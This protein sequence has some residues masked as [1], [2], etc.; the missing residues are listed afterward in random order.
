MKY[1]ENYMSDMNTET[2][3]L[4]DLDYWLAEWL[5]PTGKRRSAH[6]ATAY[7]ADVNQ[8]L[9]RA[10]KPFDQI[11]VIDLMDYQ[12]FLADEYG[13][14][15]TRARKVASVCSFYRFLNNR[16]ITSINLSRLERARIDKTINHDELLTPEQVRAV[17]AA[18]AANPLHHALLKFLYLT[19]VRISESLNLRWRDLRPL[20]GGGEAHIIGKGNKRRT[21]FVPVDLWRDLMALRG[22]ADDADHPF[23]FTVQNAW[24]VVKKAGKAA[25]IEDVH[26]HQF[27]HAYVSHLLAENVPLADVSE[28]V[29]HR[30]VSTTALYAHP[31]KGRDVASKLRA[32]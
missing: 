31:T 3:G 10:K 11:S 23:P 24:K 2:T 22:K 21:V 28:L 8:F 16:E 19:G 5:K 27:R 20:E 32:E 15:K 25:G 13:S 1:N 4:R 26:P 9:D 29:G 30:D 17:I 18:T 14:E 6:T 12:S 7:R